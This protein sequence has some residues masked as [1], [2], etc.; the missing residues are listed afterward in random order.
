MRKEI[1]PINS[2]TKSIIL[3]LYLAYRGQPTI[4]ANILPIRTNPEIPS[5][6]GAKES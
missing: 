3:S 1:I 4:Y 5:S 6:V 2:A